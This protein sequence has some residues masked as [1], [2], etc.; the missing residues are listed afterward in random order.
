MEHLQASNGS[1]DP[2]HG[3]AAATCRRP[4]SSAKPRRPRSYHWRLNQCECTES[5]NH[6]DAGRNICRGGRPKRPGELRP[7]VRFD[8]SQRA[9]TTCRVRDLSDDRRGNRQLTRTG[10]N[11]T[12]GQSPHARDTCRSRS[13]DVRSGSSHTT[14]INLLQSL[15]DQHGARVYRPEV[16]H[17]CISALRATGGEGGFIGAAMQARERNRHLGRPLGRRAVGSTLL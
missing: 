3:I 13:C 2:G 4:D 11:D 8:E 10:R 6:A 1:T 5:N 16:L 7:P 17:C 14:S 9:A 15:A 12:R